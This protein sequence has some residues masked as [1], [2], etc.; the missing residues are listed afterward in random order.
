[1]KNAKRL[2]KGGAKAVKIEGQKGVKA[3]VK[4]GVPVMG[5]LG[6]LPQSASKP[7]IQRSKKIINEAKKLEEAGV[8]SIVLEM[9]DP[10]IAKKVTETVKVPTIGIGSGKHCDGQVL[11]THDLVGLSEWSPRFVKP[12]ANLRKVVG[13]AVEEFRRGVKRL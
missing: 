4:S 1:V 6:Y 13:R 2:I 3:I 11:V 9:V 7:K 10:K 12:K 8:F 5:H